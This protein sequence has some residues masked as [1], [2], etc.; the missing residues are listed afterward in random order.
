MTITLGATGIWNAGLRFRDASAAMDAAAAAEELGYGAVWM[1]DV[2][3]DDLFPRL[4]ALLEATSRITVAT[5]VLNLWMHDAAEVG[6]HY[7]ELA[8][9]L[10]PNLAARAEA[11]PL[12]VEAVLPE[13]APGDAAAAQL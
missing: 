10:L 13:T 8:D 6:R 3:G 12:T 1:P 9:E 4:Q 7:A 5:G 2:G 11:E